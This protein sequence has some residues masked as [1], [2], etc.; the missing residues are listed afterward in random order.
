[1]TDEHGHRQHG[2]R[3]SDEDPDCEQ[4]LAELY[5]FL[6]GELTEDRRVMLTRHLDD[7]NPCLEVYDFEAEL[8]QVI[9]QRCRDDVPDSL[10]ERIAER[11]RE[12]TEPAGGSEM[13]RGVGG[14]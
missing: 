3:H 10:R 13:G 6:D 12:V 9:A 2:H 1:M 5:E 11:L 7:C 8:R 4:A 14:P